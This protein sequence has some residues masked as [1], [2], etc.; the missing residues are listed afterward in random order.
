MPTLEARHLMMHSFTLQYYDR[1][2]SVAYRPMPQGLTP[3]NPGLTGAGSNLVAS[4]RRRA[5]GKLR[6]MK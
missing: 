2:F 3:G 1:G 5:T 6:L 4:S